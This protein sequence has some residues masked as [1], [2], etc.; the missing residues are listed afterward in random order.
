MPIFY[1]FWEPQLPGEL[2]AFQGLSTYSCTFKVAHFS[3]AGYH[4]IGPNSRRVRV[5]IGGSHSGFAE[6]LFFRDE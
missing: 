4:I 6:N 5:V 1:K 3:Q 2:M